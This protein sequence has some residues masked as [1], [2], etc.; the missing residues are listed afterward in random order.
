M[1]TFSKSISCVIRF[2]RSRCQAAGLGTERFRR[3]SSALPAHSPFGKARDR[4]RTNGSI[5]DIDVQDGEDT[6]FCSPPIPCLRRGRL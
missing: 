4:L 2:V 5:T 6:L 3:V 1:R